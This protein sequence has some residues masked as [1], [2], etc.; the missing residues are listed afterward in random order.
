MCGAVVSNFMGKELK[1]DP[2]YQER[3]AKGLVKMSSDKEEKELPP[4]AKKI[5]AYLSYRACY[6]VFYA[7]Q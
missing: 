5:R 3:M 4:G 2:V 1:D 7:R 6:C